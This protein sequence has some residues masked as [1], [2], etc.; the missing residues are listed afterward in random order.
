MSL[1]DE[2][3]CLFPPQILG[4]AEKN[5]LS[6]AKM[7]SHLSSASAKAM[8]KVLLQFNRPI[9]LGQNQTIAFFILS[10]QVSEVACSD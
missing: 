6:E 2:V 5:I 4:I 10:I 9:Y 3:K 8:K 7:L 1:K